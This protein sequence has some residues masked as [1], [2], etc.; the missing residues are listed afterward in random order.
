MYLKKLILLNVRV[1]KEQLNI[2]NDLNV[3]KHS[4]AKNI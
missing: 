4:K 2:E 1:E 3:K